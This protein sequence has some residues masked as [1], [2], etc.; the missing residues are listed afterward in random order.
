MEQTLL[1][2]LAEIQRRYEAAC[3]RRTLVRA[4]VRSLADFKA[5]IA[6]NATPEEY[7]LCFQKNDTGKA[8][9]GDRPIKD[10]EAIRD[11]MIASLLHEEASV[12]WAIDMVE[13]GLTPENPTLASFVEW[14]AG[15]RDPLPSQPKPIRR[16]L[17]S[18]P[19]SSQG[20]QQAAF[21]V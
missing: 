10:A 3:F 20:H 5:W 15:Y 6:A 11:E 1:Q 21:S 14:I 17:P 2:Q 12:L 9:F 4:G 7:Q 13:S 18:Q 16:P 19:L 8:F